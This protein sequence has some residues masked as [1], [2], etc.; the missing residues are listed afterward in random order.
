MVVMGNGHRIRILSRF[1]S[2][3]LNPGLCAK[4]RLQRVKISAMLQI[5]VSSSNLFSILE[6]DRLHP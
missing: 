3:I 6:G 5:P 1:R 4:A 2:P